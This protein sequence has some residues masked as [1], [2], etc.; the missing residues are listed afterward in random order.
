MTSP[1]EQPA[2]GGIPRHFRLIVLD[3]LL[4][5]LSV[6]FIEYQTVLPALA[7]RLTGST[8]M[9][10]VIACALPIGWQGPQ[11]VVARKVETWSVKMPMYKVGAWI[12]VACNALAITLLFFGGAVPARI[13]FWSIVVLLWGAM[14][15]IGVLAVPWM[16][17]T[18]KVIPVALLPRLFSYRRLAGGFCGIGAGLVVRYILSP[19]SGLTF[20]RNYG[21]LFLLCGLV[22]ASAFLVFSQVH[23]PPGLVPKQRRSLAD[24]LRLG[25][26]LLRADPNYRWYLIV[27]CGLSAAVMGLPMLMPFAQERLS[28][29]PSLVGALVSVTMFAATLSNLLWA[30]LGDRY[31]AVGVVRATALLALVPPAVAWGVGRLPAVTWT[32]AGHS[33]SVP[34]LVFSVAFMAGGALNHGLMIGGTSYLLEVAPELVRPTYLGFLSA[35]TIPLSALPILAGLIVGS[36]SYETLFLLC[37][38]FGVFAS[39]ATRRLGGAT[40]VDELV[41]RGID[42]KLREEEPRPE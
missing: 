17:I 20:P 16:D 28:N 37:V 27:R 19:A 12:N 30:R 13:L 42:L 36:F 31:G 9:V 22:A 3:G 40:P 35:V 41:R 24:H 39:A 23:E 8:V 6:S 2:V 38:V 34:L 29:D 21:V 14:S 7:H 11:F 5:T 1:A 18:S 15:G 10:G 25:P 33:V 4:W 32:V 26:Q